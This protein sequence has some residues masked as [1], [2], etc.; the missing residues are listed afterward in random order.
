MVV[1]YGALIASVWFFLAI[2]AGYTDKTEERLY[3]RRKH[4]HDIRERSI[5]SLQNVNREIIKIHIDA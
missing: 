2:C 3:R 5:D 1:F 4:I